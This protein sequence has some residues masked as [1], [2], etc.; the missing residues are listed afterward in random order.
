MKFLRKSLAV[1]CLMGMLTSCGG[2][3][4]DDHVGN[5]ATVAQERG[6]TTLLVAV[7]KA[8]LTTELKAD[9]ANLTIFA[10]SNAAFDTLATQLGFAN[11]GELV[12]ALPASDLSKILRYHLVVGNKYAADIAAA[13]SLQTAYLF[14]GTAATL[15]LKIGASIVVTDATLADSVVMAPDVRAANGVIQ[16]VDK[17]LIPPGVLNVVQMAQAN[18]AAFSSLVGAVVSAGLVNTLSGAGQFTVFAPINS[19]FASAPAGLSNTQLASVLAYHVLPTQVLS[20][21]IP[22]GTPIATLDRLTLAGEI[23]E[24]QTI[25]INSDLT[26]T[27]TTTTPARILA[28]DVRAANGV[29]HVIGKVLIPR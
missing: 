12:N 8:G 19:A 10:P 27:D 6:F 13:G 4:D 11:A 18:P 1:L 5:L 16:V 26:I 20:T 28:A 24:P 15:Q 29:I 21:A 3:D 9:H 23:V 22:F 17:V 14:D 7:E 2:S 25:T